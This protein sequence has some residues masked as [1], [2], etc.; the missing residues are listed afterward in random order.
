MSAEISIADKINNSLPPDV[1]I[2]CDSNGRWFWTFRCV[3]SYDIK[4]CENGF[5]TALDALLNFAD[6]LIE[7]ADTLVEL[8]E[9]LEDDKDE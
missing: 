6:Y 4:G 5:D 3:E 2:E 9:I 8:I 1:A 7:G